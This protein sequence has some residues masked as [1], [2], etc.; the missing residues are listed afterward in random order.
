MKKAMILLIIII[1]AV[2]EREDDTNLVTSTAPVVSFQRVISREVEF[3]VMHILPHL[4]NYPV[5]LLG[6]TL[7]VNSQGRITPIFWF[8]FSKE[9]KEKI[10]KPADRPQPRIYMR[11]PT[12]QD[13][14]D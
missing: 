9:Y 6:R 5:H 10:N 14:G 4:S 7:E 2:I 3:R 12:S 8:T 11:R 13:K 1:V